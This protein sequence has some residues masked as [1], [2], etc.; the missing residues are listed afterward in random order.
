M[1]L[2]LAFLTVASF[3]FLY[4]NLYQSMSYGGFLK[5]GYP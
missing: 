2:G 3:R 4:V 1:G 5:W